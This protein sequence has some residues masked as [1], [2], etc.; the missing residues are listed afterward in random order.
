MI[1]QFDVYANSN[2]RTK[3]LYPLLVDVQND[4]LDLLQSRLVIPLSPKNRNEESYPKNVCPI[5]TLDG[6]DYFLLT[7]LMT[8]VSIQILSEYICSIKPHRDEIVAAI[9]F[10]VT[11][12]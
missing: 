5:L 8:S 10:A 3:S 2:T 6:Q 12:V 11:G 4:V 9:D 7:H 1:S